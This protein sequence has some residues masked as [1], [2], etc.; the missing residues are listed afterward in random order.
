MWNEQLCVACFS[1]NYLRFQD[2]LSLF[3]FA[4]SFKVKQLTKQKRE[5]EQNGDAFTLYLSFNHWVQPPATYTVS[6][7][8]V[9]T[10]FQQH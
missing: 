2:I 10:S 4:F 5:T 8:P 7:S 1:D 6:N 9:F 3:L